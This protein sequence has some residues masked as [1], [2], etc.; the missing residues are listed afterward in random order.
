L[1]LSGHWRVDSRSD[2]GGG[3]HLAFLTIVLRVI[4]TFCAFLIATWVSVHI[5]PAIFPFSNVHVSILELLSF[6]DALATHFSRA[7]IFINILLGVRVTLVTQTSDTD[8]STRPT[9]SQCRD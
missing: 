1:L 7:D 6:V 9:E 5:F 2:R 3:I 4:L 8:G